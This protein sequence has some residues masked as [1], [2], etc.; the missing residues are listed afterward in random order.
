MLWTF[1][2]LLTA[3][4]FYSRA[5]WTLKPV[6]PLQYFLVFSIVFHFYSWTFQWATPEA[7]IF[8]SD[9]PLWVRSIRHLAIILFI[10]VCLVKSRF[11][12]SSLFWYVGSIVVWISISSFVRLFT[13]DD[14]HTALFFWYTPLEFMPLAFLDF[15]E[16]LEQLLRFCIGCC[17][18]VIGFLGLEAFSDR[19]TGFGKGGLEQ[20]YGSIF[21]SPNDLGIFTVLA[22]LGV[23]VFSDRIKQPMRA[24]LTVALAVTLVVT[25][26]RGAMVGLVGGMIAVWPLSKKWFL[27]VASIGLAFYASLIT[28][29]RDTQFVDDLLLRLTNQSAIDRIN[30]IQEVKYEMLNWQPSGI[31][32]GTLHHIHQENFF[33]SVLLRAGML[34]L[35]LIS[36]L[37]ITALVKARHP[38]L[39]AGLAAFLS[40]SCFT[41]YPDS[42]PSNVYL[43]LMVGAIWKLADCRARAPLKLEVL[44]PR[45]S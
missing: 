20:R 2:L 6:T 7:T 12:R 34:G 19:A 9:A 31:V 42:F 25:G 38:F 14:T 4:L 27:T 8:D 40:A 11:R 45:L 41:P 36:V 32:F 23:M 33:L 29:F 21:G 22:L 30:E 3:F 26:S 15:E 35:I 17:W 16:D 18:I 10:V 37:M 13:V 1:F 44:R 5:Y 24:V 28:V 39:K 43:W